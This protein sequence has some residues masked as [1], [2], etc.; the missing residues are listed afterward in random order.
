MQRL[1]KLFVVSVMISTALS[2]SMVSVSTVSAKASAG[3]LIKMNG[4]SSVYYLGADGKRYVFPNEKTFMSWYGD[5]SSIVSVP[6][7]E[8]ESYPLGGN[9]VVRPGTKLVKITTNPTV[10][11]VEPNGSLRSIVSEANA[12]SLFGADWAQRVIDVP[13]AFFTN[14]VV[15]SPLTAGVY[16]VGTIVKAA[17]SA[18]VYYFDGSNYRKLASEAALLANRLS[19]SNVVTAPATMT[20]TAG[21]T[22]ISGVEAALTN[23]AATPGAGVIAGTTGTGLVVA[24]S[25]ATAAATTILQGQALANLGT[26]NLTASNDGAVKVTTLK[27]TRTGIAADA[28]V[29]NV[30]LFDGVT[31]LTDAGSFSSN[32]ASFNAAA[33]LFTI[34]AG[35]TK[36]IT[37][38]ADMASSGSTIGVKINAASDIIT[39]GGSTVS[40][41]FPVSGNIMSIAAVTSPILSTVTVNSVS[42]VGAS[43]TAGTL[44]A[45]LFTSTFAVTTKEVQM[46]YVRFNEVGSAP[47]DALQNIKLF[48]NGSQVG[49]TGTIDASG[50]VAFDLSSAPAKLATNNNTVELRGDVVKGSNRTFTF[51][52]QAT[53]DLVLMDEN[54]NVSVSAVN[55]PTSL[56]A[57]TIGTGNVS[58]TADPTFTATQAVKSSTGVTLARYT[59]KALGEDMKVQTLT[60]T[61]TISS[62]TLAAGEGLSN[63]TLYVNGSAVGSTKNYLATSANVL[64]AV[65]TFGTTNL[66]TIPAGTTVTLEIR[67]DLTQDATSGITAVKA[68]LSGG[69][70]AFFGVSS[71]QT[72]AGT[73]YSGNPTLTIVS[74]A[75]SLSANPGFQSQIALANTVNQK[76]GSFILQAGSAEAVKVS[77]IAVGLATST[78]TLSHLNNLYIT[79]NTSPITSIQNTN[80]FPVSYTIPVNGSKTFDVFADLGANITA[81]S[82]TATYIT[83]TANGA[84]TNNSV[85]GI[86]QGQ[87]ITVQAGALGAPSLVSNDPLS[88]LV[89]GGTSFVA[90]KYKFTASNG[91]AT[92]S[93][94][95]IAVTDTAT[96][97]LDTTAVASVTVGGVTAAPVNGTAT[98]SGLSIVV[99]AGTQGL[100]V[101]VTV[102]YNPVRSTGL[103]GSATRNDV[104][105]DLTSYK[106]S[107]ANA[108]PVTV[109]GVAYPSNIMYLV[110]AVPTVSLAADAPRQTSNANADMGGNFEVLRFT[111]SAAGGDINLK[112][113]GLKPV[114]TGTLTSTSSQNFN[115]YDISDTNNALGSAVAINISGATSTFA[116]T[117]DYLI[118]AGTTKEFVVKADTTGLS[119]TGNTFRLD[120]VNSDDTTIAAA[121][122]W[123]WNDATV[124]TYQGGYLVK[125][126]SITGN[127]F[128]R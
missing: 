69:A 24:L 62:T 6:Q 126:L 99:P 32:V 80:N 58:V 84:S 19:M 75:L 15:N 10:Y 67:A 39:S 93:D 66:F 123:K 104:R 110:A 101:P 49:T 68:T 88:Q 46:N 86:V 40:G 106:Y 44:Q 85:G 30:Y 61:P 118:A 35:Q 45:V 29:N 108:S 14:Y 105:L 116:L 18:D 47:V 81:G 60:V 55:V 112:N 117:S 109:T 70:S 77:N 95:T 63:I 90:A 4:L 21:G 33:G 23:T 111:V 43:V 121:T 51:N 8:L 92:I 74:G 57:T 78:A 91:N 103:G 98:F 120:L 34:P 9:V 124:G 56:T 37:V 20:I 107:V 96:S 54:Y 25:S 53:A 125:N 1:R 50:N 36:S 64:P 97:S 3:D 41:S 100:T 128:T 82:T 113:V 42:S 7:S 87:T 31:R 2:M 94:L 71:S 122:D 114:Y 76:I 52:I 73:S 115:I 59:M 26:F 119:T 127:T 17:N 65:P 13:D 72:V 16:P 28:S 38:K 27:V 12:I 11:A 22:T 5:F 89:V 83:V 102:A 48:V 79:D